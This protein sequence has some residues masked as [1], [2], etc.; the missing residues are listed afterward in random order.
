MRRS[1]PIPRFRR[2]TLLLTLASAAAA[3]PAIATEAWQQELE[4]R[5]YRVV[6]ENTEILNYR[7]N[8]WI[9]LD[10]RHLIINSGPK[11]RYLVTFR[12]PCRELRTNETIA[13]TNTVNR[14][15]KF[16][17]AIVQGA[18]NIPENCYIESIH[19]LEKIPKTRDSKQN[20]SKQNPKQTS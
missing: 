8:G 14:L 18:G 6:G 15:T 20:D 11:E 12:S 13:F 7:F 4:Q 5:G 10:N 3:A 2:A 9:P 19:A 16:D 1:L 17:K